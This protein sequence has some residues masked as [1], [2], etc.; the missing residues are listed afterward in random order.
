[1]AATSSSATAKSRALSVVIASRLFEDIGRVFQRAGDGVTEHKRRH[2]EQSADH[3]QQKSIF[4]RR[5]PPAVA[6]K[7]ARQL[8]CVNHQSIF[9]NALQEYLM[10]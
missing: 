1:L 3:G 4:R 8:E 6:K 7:N 9:F 5:G 2:R 10:W